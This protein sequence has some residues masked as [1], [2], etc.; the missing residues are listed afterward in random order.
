MFHLTGIQMP[1]Y[2]EYGVVDDDKKK[3]VALFYDLMEARQFM[4]RQQSLD[5]WIKAAADAATEMNHWKE[6][7]LIAE[8]RLERKLIVDRVED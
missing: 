4:E 1:P 3:T 8:E 6:R 7:A 5:S 2:P